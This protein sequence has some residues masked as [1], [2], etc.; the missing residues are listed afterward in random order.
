MAKTA[1]ARI[2]QE[3]HD[4]PHI[5]GHRVTVRRIQGLV[6]EVGQSP[7]EVAEELELELADVY[8]ALHYYHTHTEEM[9]EAERRHQKRVET[10]AA[11]GAKSLTDYEER[12]GTSR[13]R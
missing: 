11:S 3:V 12:D 7:V 1:A 4:E 6:E 10:A 2:V 13:T 8:A 9:A 5:E